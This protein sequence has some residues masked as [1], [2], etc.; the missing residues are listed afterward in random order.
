MTDFVTRARQIRQ[1]RLILSEPETG[2]SREDYDR[3]LAA[4]AVERGRAPQTAT[5]HT[6]TA[7]TLGLHETHLA[8]AVGDRPLLITSAHYP[9]R[10]ITLYY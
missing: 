6:E 3:E 5:M 10:T 4:Y 1:Q 9:P 7:V 2:W 8:P